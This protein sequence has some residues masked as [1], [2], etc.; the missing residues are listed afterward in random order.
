MPSSAIDELTS[1]GYRIAELLRLPVCPANAAE[2]KALEHAAGIFAFL[3]SQY[4]TDNV[5][6]VVAPEALVAEQYGLLR[7]QLTETHA[8]FMI[9]LASEDSEQAA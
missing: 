7:G 2:V 3:G 4:G 9:R 1:E 5:R 8:A 6:A